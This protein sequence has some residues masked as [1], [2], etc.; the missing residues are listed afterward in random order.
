MFKVVVR[1]VAVVVQSG[2]F[3]AR[4]LRKIGLGH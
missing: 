1:L 2:L 3:V 4:L